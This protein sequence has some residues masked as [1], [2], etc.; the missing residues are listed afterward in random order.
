MFKV[1]GLTETWQEV[2]FTT[3]GLPAVF[4]FQPTFVNVVNQF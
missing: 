2:S 3:A 4:L 1:S